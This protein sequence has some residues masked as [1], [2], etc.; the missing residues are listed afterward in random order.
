WL[1]I[2]LQAIFTN[3]LAPYF[4]YLIANLIAIVVTSVLNFV[5]N[6]IWTFGRLKLMGAQTSHPASPEQRPRPFGE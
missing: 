3:V 1:S 2:A 4:Y 5:L 6:D